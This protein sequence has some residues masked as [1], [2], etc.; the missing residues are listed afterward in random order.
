MNINT[1]LYNARGLRIGHSEADKSHR[2]VVD[3]LQEACDVLCVQE[4]FLSK[5]D[6]EGLNSLLKDF[7]GAGESSTDLS[8]RIVH[9]GIPGGVALLWHTKYD[10]LINV[11][12]LDVDWAIGIQFKCGDKNFTI[13]NIYTPYECSQNKDEYLDR[14]ACVMAFI[15]DNASTLFFIVGDMNADVSDGSSVFA[16]Y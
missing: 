3:K 9:S 5:Q 8:T 4:T 14:L 1:V 15:Q 6:L 10:Q 2:L 12:R 13:L 11:V 7:Y 16:K